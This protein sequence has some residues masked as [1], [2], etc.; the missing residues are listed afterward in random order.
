MDGTPA[1]VNRLAVEVVREEWRVPQDIAFGDER[2]VPLR[3]GDTVP[4]KLL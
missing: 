4:W 1:R 2:L 3:A